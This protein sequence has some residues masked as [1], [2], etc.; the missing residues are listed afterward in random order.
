MKL[1]ITVGQKTFDKFD[2]FEVEKM[3]EVA[4]EAKDD[5]FNQ[6][7][8]EKSKEMP[9]MVDF[10]AD[11]CMPC[12]MLGPSLDNVAKKHEGKFVLAK[13]NVDQN[14]SISNEYGIMSIPSVKLFKDGKI[15]D[16]FVGALP[17]PQ[18]ESW[19]Q[20]HL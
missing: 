1:I 11:W 20:N 8:I 3:S 7:V 4:I 15:V 16:E 12:K 5:T 10:W 13:V 14:P 9:V 19:L 2:I 17:E 6:D 18:V